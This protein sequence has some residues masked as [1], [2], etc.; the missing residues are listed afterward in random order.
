M[1]K[2]SV[3][4]FSISLGSWNKKYDWH[5]LTIPILFVRNS[6]IKN[7]LTTK[8]STFKSAFRSGQASRPYS[9]TGIHLLRSNCST[10]S[11]VTTLPMQPNNGI[12]SAM[13]STSRFFRRNFKISGAD[14]SDT[15]ILHFLDPHIAELW[16]QLSDIWH[17]IPRPFRD[18]IHDI[19]VHLGPIGAPLK[20]H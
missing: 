18:R 19:Y 8:S 9:R 1:S 17:Q 5:S 7:L 16:L 14:N 10:T 11:S 3:L 15:K 20:F 13:K 12:S 6:L 4:C 2:R